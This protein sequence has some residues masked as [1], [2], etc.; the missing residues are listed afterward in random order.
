MNKLTK[1]LLLI[2][3]MMPGALYAQKIVTVDVKANVHSISPYIY[4][5]NEAYENS[6]ATRWG[7]NRSSS[8]NWENNASNSGNDYSFT[9]DNFYD[10]SG[11]G[12]NIPGYPI[13]NAVKTADKNGQFSLV[14]IQAAGYVAADAKGVVSQQDVAPSSRWKPISFH[15]SEP[16][17][18]TPD[19]EDDTVYIDEL[20]NYLTTKLG[21]PGDG[22]ISAY[23]VDNEPYLWN[24]THA[25][26]HPNATTPEELISK[27][28]SVSSVVKTLAPGTEVFGPMFF[29]W[30]DAYMWGMNAIQWNKYYKLS[31]REGYPAKYSWFVDYYLDTLYRYEKQTGLRPVDAIAFH[32]YP[33]SFGLVTKK[34]IVNVE[35][36][37]I[38]TTKNDLITDDMIEAR[39]QAPRGLWDSKYTYYG[40][41]G[42]PSYVCT[43]GGRAIIPKIKK[44]IENFNPS[45][46]IA[47]TEFEYDAEEHW[48][49]G[50][51]LVDVLGVFGREDV[52]LACKW[53]IFKNYSTAAYDLYL[54]YDAQ[55]GH[56]GTTSVFAQQSDTAALSSFASLDEKGNLHIIVVNKTKDSQHT[57]F[58][59]ENGL[60]SS[61]VVYGFGQQ[62]SKI[63]QL[64][65][66]DKVENGEFSYAIPAYSAVHIILNSVPQ[67]TL[68]EAKVDDLDNSAIVL[69]FTDK[70]SEKTAS[71]IK[72]EFSVVVN[73]NNS[74]IASVT[75]DNNIAKVKLVNSI[76]STDKNIKVSYRGENVIGQSN[77]PIALF[78]TAFVYNEIS[79]SEFYVLSSQVDELGR[80]FT[81][82][83][84]RKTGAITEKA[85]LQILQNEEMISIDSVKKSDFSDYEVI[86][87][88]SKRILR[89]LPTIVST[90][91]N[92]SLSAIDGTMVSDFSMELVG[93]GNYSPVIDSVRI[94]DNYTIKLY[95]SSNLKTDVDYANAGF[96][97]IDGSGNSL[98]FDASYNEFRRY[99]TFSMKKALVAGVDYTLS[100]KDEGKVA[101]IHNGVLEDFDLEVE[102]TLQDMGA[103][104]TPIP[105][106]VQAEQYWSCV[107]T[108]AVE[109][110]SDT[111]SLGNGSSLG[112]IS[113]NDFYSYK[114]SVPEDKNYTVYVRYS[115]ESNGALN[116][117]IDG[118]KYHMTLP[119]T[120]SFSTWKDVYRVL[121][122]Q[123]GEHEITMSIVAS[124]FNVNYI[125]FTDEEK[126]PVTTITKAQVSKSG[127][128]MMVF[129][130][131]NIATLPEPSEVIVTCNDTAS[132]SVKSFDFNSDA[133]LNLYFDTLVYKG[134]TLSMRF[135]STALASADGGFV[136]D[137]TLSVINNSSLVYKAPEPDDPTAVEEL[138]CSIKV[139]PVPAQVNQPIVLSS[140]ERVSYKVISANGS[141]LEQGDCDGEKS[142][143]LSK[144][145]TYSI[146]ITKDNTTIVKKII[147]R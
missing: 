137:T 49:G 110:C 86:V 116:F 107:G 54:N 88:P 2:A 14:S 108:P 117:I 105:G 73:G 109:E 139:S 65:N 128:K 126:Y 143:S 55:G 24:S 91:S 147:V 125:Q 22:G 84:S 113:I 99:I 103:V 72:N 40:A 89:Y 30:S 9:S 17:T 93:G 50:L 80:N 120:R 16:Y 94:E 141:I 145:G 102:N 19:A 81:L 59:I 42:S 75:L 26:M 96:S 28:I 82:N 79:G 123:A 78:D 67:T 63:T 131:T 1:S 51:C 21:K 83:F 56:F 87:Y 119:S 92:T 90:S 95:F 31:T 142:I 100:L 41:N 13:L 130:N 34:R 36:T 138:L 52:Y 70:L 18:L 136:V 71:A 118:V 127:D 74:E 76:K 39:L 64:D 57:Q 60:Y 53:D 144:E 106:V 27:T 115:S 10:A 61:G 11:S 112:Y 45:M 35:S 85:G 69:N 47:F 97:V 111:S 62:S 77:L 134:S 15:K 66:V 135:N 46:K 7:G 25:R 33:E 114:I 122:L 43:Q 98:D 32:W 48:S 104:L 121:P 124:G 29:G 44:S 37:A 140:L 38:S 146:V 133:V 5:T 6:T 23:A 3:G 58:T 20:V 8:Y 129:F 4:G 68:V 12:K 101:T 132:I